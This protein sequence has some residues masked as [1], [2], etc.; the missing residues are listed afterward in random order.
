MTGK[1]QKY[2]LGI[3]FLLVFAAIFLFWAVGFPHAL[4]YQE[5]YQLFLFTGDYFMERL[6]MPGGVAAFIG[7]FLTQFYYIEYLGAF[8]L[9]LIAISS[10]FF[11]FLLIKDYGK[12]DSLSA[13]FLSLV[14]PIIMIGLMGD[15]NLLLSYFVSLLA[16]LKSSYFFRNL[17]VFADILIIPILYWCFG[18]MVW[19]YI[20]LKM[21]NYGWKYASMAI[22]TIILQW[23]VYMVLLPQ[24]PWI[25]AALGIY[26][27]RIPLPLLLPVLPYVAPFIIALT[28]YVSKGIAL[29][30]SSIVKGCISFLIALS[31]GFL[32]Y[33]SNPYDKEKYEL[34]RQD[35][36]VRFE[37][38]DEIIQRA[39]KFQVQS[40]FFSNCINLALS[41]TGQLAEKQFSFYQ[42]GEDALLMPSVQ[43][44]FSNI[45]TSEAFY[46]LGM[47][48]SALRYTFDLQES[49]LNGQKSGRFCK[50]LAECY[51]IKGNHKVAKKYIDLLKKSLF[52]RKWA[53]TADK[54]IGK[55]NMV[56][57]NPSWNTARKFQFK[58]DFLY[59]Y[60]EID[61]MLGQLFVNNTDN[62]MAL[63]Y[64]L[65]ELLL[66]GNVNEFVHYLS[67]AQ[68][69]GGY[70]EMPAGYQD[71]MRAIQSKGQDL[72]S[73]YAKYIN[74]K[75]RQNENE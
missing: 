28:V 43:E 11:L 52:Y 56:M 16:I 22:Y 66:K 30:Q 50:R 62:K 12:T 40:P 55:D 17:I 70:K 65:G 15:E 9:S 74:A 44:L 42:S 72:T 23:L 20:I 29:F 6:S 47:I 5:Q 35:Y 32:V 26:Y 48:N 63:E 41:Q 2:T 38:W 7:E 53:N 13:F 3:G 46:R 49:I 19:L 58:E 75:L 59:H 60:P 61:K 36:L 51:L 71:A 57:V 24:T 45:P 64:F 67:W 73:A 68:Q 27:Y 1:I 18:P 21:G 33:N 10:Q 14:F 34:I 31:V 8:F 69:Y 37:K 54:Y 25:E 4:S 39:E